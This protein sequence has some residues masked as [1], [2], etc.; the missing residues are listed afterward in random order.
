MPFAARSIAAAALAA[1]TLTACGDK[2]SS[3]APTKSTT[4]AKATPATPATKDWLDVVT[5]T[6]EGGFKQGNPDAKVK[7]LEFGSLTCSHCG[8]FAHEGVPELRAKYIATGKVSY[9][10]RTFIL[11]GVDFAPS[12][13]V[14]CQQPAAALKLIDAFYDQQAVWT[15][16]F[17]KP[18]P[19]DVQ[20]KLATL[21]QE[22]Q[23]TE[24][25]AQGGLDAFMRTRGMTRAK[26]DQC[27]SDKAGIAALTAIRD[28][29]TNKYKLQGTPTF[30]INGVTQVDTANW[31]KLKPLL[32]AAVS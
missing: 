24:F 12:L 13:L 22:Q 29:A 31:A 32:D 18:L 2:A 10:Y 8:A 9:E 30:V 16:P 25:A 15:V 23:I 6:P 19:D 11:N 26:F 1:L 3:A 14:R 27:T 28:E 5:M 17:T 21:P 7:L 4:A 20:K